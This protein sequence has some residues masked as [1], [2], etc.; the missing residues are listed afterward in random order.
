MEDISS[1][2]TLRDFYRLKEVYQR[3]NFCKITGV[4]LEVKD[5]ELAANFLV[6]N[7][8]QAPS[9]SQA[10]KPQPINADDKDD[11][12][13]DVVSEDNTCAYLLCFSAFTG[14]SRNFYQRSFPRNHKIVHCSVSDAYIVYAVVQET[15]EIKLDESMGARPELGIE[16]DEVKMAKIAQ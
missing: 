12:S 4:H 9:D 2:C 15:P 13:Q 14:K 11:G 10:S 3:N 5:I 6:S 8:L 7:P 16:A 1:V